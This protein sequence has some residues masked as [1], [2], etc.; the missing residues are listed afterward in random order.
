MHEMLLDT[1]VQ[2]DIQWATGY[3]SGDQG[4]RLE[5]QFG[6]TCMWVVFNA[7]KLGEIMMKVNLDR[8]DK[9]SKTEP[10][11]KVLALRV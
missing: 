11:G 10:W 6:I 8:K 4:K 2:R 3:T 5:F 7:M 1:Q 9:R